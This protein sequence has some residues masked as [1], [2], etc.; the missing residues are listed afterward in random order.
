MVSRF[1]LEFLASY[2]NRLSCASSNP[3]ARSNDIHVHGD[4]MTCTRRI[5][6]IALG[7][8]LALPDG[9][10]LAQYVIR[11]PDVSQSLAA[12]WS[13]A[14]DEAKAG[15]LKEGLW[16]GYGIRRWMGER[17]HIGS[18]NTA[19]WGIR[20]SLH[21]FLYGQKEF[22][23]EEP[24]EEEALRREA[25]RAL[26][27]KR[28]SGKDDPKVI[29]GIAILFGYNSS[30]KN[31]SE[32]VKL[33]VSNLS[34]AVDLGDRPLLWLGQAGHDEGASHLITLFESI[35]PK[36]KEQLLHAISIHDSSEHAYAF[37]K[38][39]LEVGETE[40]LRG[41]SAFW[42]GQANREGDI[43][44]L[45]STATDDRSKHVREQAVF[46][47]SLMKS[48]KASLALIHL[49]KHGTTTEVRSKAI[50]WLGQ[51]ASSKIVPMLKEMA[52]HDPDTK[53]QKEA[54][55]ALSRRKDGDGVKE[56]IEIART[57]HKAEVR[58]QAIFWLGQSKDPRALEALSEMVR[59][60]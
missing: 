12:K 2:V 22:P 57:H 1:F 13:W 3:K 56:L 50:F 42:I 41:H 59:G 51:K 27:G 54:V 49:A 8:I 15:G 23:A 60:R 4:S 53:L 26:E 55:F 32:P 34:L 24:D 21:E 10:L 5:L 9:N 29:K 48:E 38:K 39:Q 36:F 31:F 47:L 6:I 7:A 20:P 44:L 58:R 28:G 14:V 35:S 46:G 17:S 45:V 30:S 18:F 43:T 40:K 19:E 25:R 16:I 37:L 52:D 11:H 33:I